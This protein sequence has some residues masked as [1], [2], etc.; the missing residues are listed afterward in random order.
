MGRECEGRVA[1]VTGAS[2]GIGKAIAVRLAAEGAAL[3]ICSR[4][5][6]GIAQLGT[7]E[8]TRDEIAALGGSVVAI[9]FD[10]SDPSLDRAALVDDVERELGPVDILVNNAA[11]SGFRP[12]LEWTDAQIATVLELNFW[13]CWHLIRRVLPGMLERHEGWILN[14]SSQTATM[15]IGPPFPNTQPARLG[16][17][18]GG[19]KAFLNRWTTSLAVELYGQGI[20]VNTIAPQA[21][22]ATEALVTYSD[23]PDYLYEP[24][25]TMA[26]GALA[27]CTADHATLTGQITTSLQLLADLQR[28]VYDL[29]G[30]QLL[31]D[32]QPE[33]LPPRIE[34]M[35]QHATGE[36]TYGPTGVERVTNADGVLSR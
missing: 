10:L 7:L 24:L 2:R 22:A 36:I 30:V 20:A 15:P 16:T 27:L 23:L 17:I 31:E 4:P 19:T 12:F 25:E 18:Y 21:A 35:R 3:A 28:P 1:L 8:E 11:G 33:Q 6:P 9:P 29:R 32:W 5:S 13:S 34:K 14:V 26:E